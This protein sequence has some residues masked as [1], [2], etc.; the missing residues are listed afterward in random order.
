MIEVKELK[1]VDLKKQI[2]KTETN[3]ALGEAYE[4]IKRFSQK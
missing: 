4:I 2:I 1:M 3:K